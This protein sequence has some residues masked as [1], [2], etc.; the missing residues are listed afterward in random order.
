MD[1]ASPP[2]ASPSVSVLPDRMPSIDAAAL[3]GL[4]GSARWP[5]VLDV[6]RAPAHDGERCS[7]DTPCEAAGLLGLSRLHADDDAA[8]LEAAIPMYDALSAWR[9]DAQHESHRWQPGAAR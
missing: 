5:Q 6:R 1:T 2:P 8:M 3:R 7:F 4:A 9:R